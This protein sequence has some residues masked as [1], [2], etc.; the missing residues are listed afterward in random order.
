MN[1]QDRAVA[2]PVGIS[3]D[4]PERLWAG[5][6]AGAAEEEGTPGDPT[7]GVATMGFLMAALGWRR[8]G[9]G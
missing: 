8:T 4:L 2:W 5:E 1:E 9:Y 3:D 7:V 6:S